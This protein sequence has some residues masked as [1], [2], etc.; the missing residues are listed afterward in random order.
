[1]AAWRHTYGSFSGN[2]GVKSYIRLLQWEWR[3]DVTHAGFSVGI[4]VWRLTYG[5]FSGNGGVKSYIRVFQ[6]EWRR[7]VIHTGVTAGMAAAAPVAVADSTPQVRCNVKPPPVNNSFLIRKPDTSPGSLA[8]FQCTPSNVA[9]G[10]F[11]FVARWCLANGTW[12]KPNRDCNGERRHIS[13]RT[14]DTTQK[15][16]SLSRI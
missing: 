13:E 16:F 8:M 1:M 2:S 7:D 14:N 5:C 3:R 6:R 12:G 4:V 10:V 15:W 9:L 11:G